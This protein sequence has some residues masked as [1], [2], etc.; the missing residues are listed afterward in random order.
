M[1]TTAYV[2]EVLTGWILSLA[3]DKNWDLLVTFR[4]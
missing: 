2:H 1:V 3:T 4:F